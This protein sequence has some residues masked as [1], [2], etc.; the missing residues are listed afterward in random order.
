MN[1]SCNVKPDA[2]VY[3]IVIKSAGKAGIIFHAHVR[4]LGHFQDPYVRNVIMDAYGKYGCTEIARKVFD[5]MSSRKVADWNSMISGYWKWGNEEEACRLFN[6]MPERNVVTWTAMITGYVKVKDLESARRY[7][8]E[9]PE[10]SVV[11]WNAMISGYAQNGFTEEVLR[12][13]NDMM[14]SGVQPDET[15]WVSVISSCSSKGDP[16]LAELVVKLLDGKGIDM[17]YFVKTALLDM[18]A[19]CGNIKIAKRIF[20]ELGKNRNVVSWNAMISAYTRAGELK[21]S[22][23]LFDKMP[24][25]NV[26]SWNSMISGYAQNGQ[27]AEAIQLFKQMIRTANSNDLKPDEVTMAVV[28]SA[29]AHLG[30][31]ELGSWVVKYMIENHI[32]LSISGY[33]SLIFMYAKC[34]SMRDAEKVFQGME[35]RDVV[36]YNTLIAGLAAHGNGNQALKFMSKMREEGLEADR[37]TYIGVLTACSH[38]GLLKEGRQVFESIKTPGVDHYACMVDLLGRM[39]QLDKAKRLI[40]SMPIEPHA[41]VYGALLNASRIHKRLD[42]GEFAADKLFQLEPNNSGNYILLSN[43]YASAGRWEDVSRMREIMRQLGVKKT[44]G[45]SWVEYKGKMHK[46]IVGDRSHEL[47]AEIYRLLGKLGR[48]MRSLGYM[49][50]KSCVLRDVEE[51]EK[52][53]MV[54]THSEKLAIC[55]ALLVCEAESVIRVVKNLRVCWDCH[56]YIKIISKLEKREIVVRDNNRFHHF[57]NGTCSCNDYW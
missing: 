40:D 19:K 34:G 26:V 30:A 1:N 31:L 38:S 13:F 51:E 47:T 37:I 32:K 41:G 21:S 33:N 48:K 15:T 49:A 16:E 10:K 27:S 5:E 12:L 7:F 53:E 36:S 2:Y 35:E 14:S 24:E 45:W 9:M 55:F 43:I 56:T 54:G 6:V 29:C 17:N 20:D 39:G 46:F 22:R 42:L 57:V 25:R 4:K 8:N 11:S 23:E 50:D 52:E 18:H 44:T 28:I 3:P